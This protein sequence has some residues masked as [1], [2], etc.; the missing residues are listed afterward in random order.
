MGD[1]P[2]CSRGH[3]NLLYICRVSAVQPGPSEIRGWAAHARLSRALI[4]GS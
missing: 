4:W 1:L 2:H 3:M